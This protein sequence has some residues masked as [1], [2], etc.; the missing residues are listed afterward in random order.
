MTVTV[1]NWEGSPASS[2]TRS[3]P[4]PVKLL[5]RRKPELTPLH[6]VVALPAT[7]ETSRKLATA[8][9][10]FRRRSVKPPRSIRSC[11]RGSSQVLASAGAV[12]F[13]SRV[14]GGALPAGQAGS[15]VQRC[16]SSQAETSRADAAPAAEISEYL[17][18]PPRAT[19]RQTA[20]LTEASSI[21]CTGRRRSNRAATAT[22]TLI[23]RSIIRGHPERR[24]LEK[25]GSPHRSRHIV[26]TGDEPALRP[27]PLTGASARSAADPVGPLRGMRVRCG[28]SAGRPRGSQV[29]IVGLIRGSA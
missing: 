6:S 10:S 12:N 24:H 26:G 20:R 19:L 11:L 4:L 15:L 7:R 22:H 9:R 27:T 16:L 29:R 28:V 2:E 8:G 21:Q 1:T 18:L 5:R 14:R 13:G 17:Q 23:G 3:R 25:E